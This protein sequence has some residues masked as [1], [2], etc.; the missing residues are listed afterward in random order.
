MYHV[1]YRLPK[2]IYSY[3]LPRFQCEN[4]RCEA[5]AL[6]GEAGALCEVIYSLFMMKL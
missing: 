6:V 5:R 4:N 3:R 1:K 2:V